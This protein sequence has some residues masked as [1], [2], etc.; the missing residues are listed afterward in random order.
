MTNEQA[1]AVFNQAIAAANDADQIAKLELAREYFT[2]SD[3]RKGLEQH[4][5][6][7]NSAR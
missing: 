4:V 1:R 3:F 5:W 2:N 6:E 7:I